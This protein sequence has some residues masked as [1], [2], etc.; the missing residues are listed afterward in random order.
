MSASEGDALERRRAA[1]SGV[2][3]IVCQSVHGKYGHASTYV[4]SR[5]VQQKVRKRLMRTPAAC[6]AVFQ[7]CLVHI[8]RSGAG[9]PRCGRR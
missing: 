6:A 5:V 9:T 2:E 1:L 8:R 7:N 3:P 4:C